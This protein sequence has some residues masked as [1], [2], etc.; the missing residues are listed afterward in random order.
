V[1]TM[2]PRAA[3]L[4]VLAAAC[5]LPLLVLAAGNTGLLGSLRAL[6]FLHGYGLLAVLAALLWVR[7]RRRFAG[8]WLQALVFFLLLGGGVGAQTVQY[9][10]FTPR[11][12]GSN[13]AGEFSAIAATIGANT[14][15]IKLPWV[16]P[17][18]CAVSSVTVPENIALDFSNS[19]G[20]K[21][22]TG[23][24][25]TIKGDMFG[26][27]GQQRFYNA[28]AGLGTVSFAGNTA[29]K[30][31]DPAWWGAKP[32]V[33]AGFDGS[34]SSSGTT[35]TSTGA[36][37]T[38]SL[39]GKSLT[40]VNPSGANRHA[41]VSAVTNSTHL[42]F[43]PAVS[44]TGSTLRYAAGTELAS[45]LQASLTAAGTGHVGRV[46]LS[47][48]PYLMLSGT[49]DIP[50][51]VSL[52]GEWFDKWSNHIGGF[53]NTQN[54]CTGN[55]YAPSDVNNYLAGDSTTL[56]VD[57]DEGAATGYLLRTGNHAAVKGV[58]FW[59]IG[60]LSQLATPKSYPWTIDLNGYWSEAGYI[61]LGLAYQAIR[62]HDGDVV[63]VH[64]ITGQPVL[65]GVYAHRLYN[66]PVFKEIHFVP[67]LG[68]LADCAVPTSL[69]PLGLWITAHG[70]GLKFGRVDNAEL[71]SFEVWG[72]NTGIQL[73]ANAESE[74][75]HGPWMS[76][77]DGVIESIHPVIVEDTQPAV[78][79]QGA[80][81]TISK[82][83]MG[84]Y[85]LLWPGGIP[86]GNTPTGIFIQSTFA[87][88]L[89]VENSEISVETAG[90][91]AVSVWYE[92]GATGTLW[93][94]NNL[95]HGETGAKPL[96]L[97]GPA[98]GS[99]VGEAYVTANKI[100]RTGSVKAVY[101]SGRMKAIFG[102]NKYNTPYVDTF[103]TAGP[104]ALV[105]S[106]SPVSLASQ[107]CNDFFTDNATVC[108]LVS[109]GGLSIGQ[110]VLDFNTKKLKLP[111]VACS[112]LGTP[113]NNQMAYCGDCQ[114]TSDPC[115]CGGTGSYAKGL[116]GRWVCSK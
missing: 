44:F 16:S 67:Q 20:L 62:A 93:L 82:V 6:A 49:V 5:A 45:P 108:G 69:S 99:T 18:R 112:D 68:Y 111:G 65:I 114:E 64:H 74:G 103:D 86:S 78:S 11:C 96:V 9:A 14:A 40:I 26:P 56:V 94:T 113:A 39:V 51:G 27:A 7:R 55:Q 110:I 38:S 60:E 21:V 102:M 79:G 23:Q 1:K 92:Q 58:G 43:S 24:T 106:N 70:T 10:N 116:N 77:H 88:N 59:Y 3:L 109:T 91:A 13:D 84:S 66:A 35:L 115:S 104:P 46:R 33:V 63:N 17:A 19:T 37:F 105:T 73:L 57:A 101:L 100:E 72:Y 98:S 4:L 48:G 8:P 36:A 52:E 42:T 50:Q 80:G 95:I 89:R 71:G 47:R 61:E 90:G 30:V 85:S 53:P 83:N 31:V 32:D 87:G 34:V 41:T 81:V 97:Q 12:S 75:L 28:T 107:S 15:S 29:L 76:I 22:N 2:T 25:L 54:T